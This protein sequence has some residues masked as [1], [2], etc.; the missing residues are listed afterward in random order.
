[1]NADHAI[2]EAG[3]VDG[4]DAGYGDGFGHGIAPLM[5][6]QR[7]LARFARASKTMSFRCNRSQWRRGIGIVIPIVAVIFEDVKL[8]V[9]RTD[10]FQHVPGIEEFQGAG[11][12]GEAIVAVRAVSLIFDLGLN[13]DVLGAG[14]RCNGN[15]FDA[16]DETEGV[17][18]G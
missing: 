9:G 10:E 6:A 17:A 14:D 7:E 18:D 12:F 11:S 5:T 2:A 1:M 3:G 8:P 15:D 13:L 16:E 4:F